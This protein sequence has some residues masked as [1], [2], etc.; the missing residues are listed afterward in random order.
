MPRVS[1]VMPVWRPH[2][3]YL[4]R[5]VDSVLAQTMSDLELVIIEDPG[6]VP[7]ASALAGLADPRIR[8]LTSPV[9][10]TL[11]EQRNRGLAA[12][13]AELVAMLDGD[14]VASPDRLALQLRR[15]AEESDLAV[16]GSA[17]MLID[18]SERPIAVRRY[19]CDHASIVS[20]MRRENPIAQGAVMAR[21]DVLVADGG[22]RFAIDHTGEDYELWSRLARAGVRFANL[23]DVAMKYRI[24]A[25]SS[26]ST[27]LRALLRST[28]WVKQHY[29]VGDM[30]AIDRVR[31]LAERLL[32]HV[33]PAWVNALFVADRR[34]RDASRRS[35]RPAR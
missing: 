10:T 23:P 11:I 30:G 2:A 4:R 18:E 17:I 24:H 27:R 25:A 33:P 8:V 22:Y 32:V 28:V 26:K 14:D 16:L 34:L 21:R 15:F 29:W 5:A 9:R 12:A 35:Q 19:P 1:V 13:R 20:A 7:V 31:M 6:G 3:T